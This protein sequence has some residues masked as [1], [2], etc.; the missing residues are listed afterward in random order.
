MTEEPRIET[1]LLSHD[2]SSERDEVKEEEKMIRLGKR[3]LIIYS[4]FVLFRI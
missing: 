2:K 3:M 1:F 4:V